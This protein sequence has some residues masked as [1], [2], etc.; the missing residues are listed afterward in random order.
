MSLFGEPEQD[1]APSTR[2]SQLARS[3]HSLFDEENSTAA[4]K[5]LFQDDDVAGSG[6]ASPW[7]LPTPRK[8]RSRAE[9]LQ[10]ILPAS[11]APESYI[12]AF[13]DMLREYG[14]GG[15]VTAGGV[16]RVLAAAKL[17]ADAQAKIINI[18]S[19]GGGELSLGRNEFNVLL[20]LIGLAQE[21]ETVSLD[22]VD[23]RRRSKCPFYSK[24][25]ETYST[26]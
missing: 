13:D 7:A 4:S 2:S 8:Q 9:L 14:S 10:N 20:G 16:M 21:G 17:G 18:I 22:G 5:S 26:I 15:K 24:D 3:R 11:D 1:E 12:E 25:S 6:A 19:P 23:E